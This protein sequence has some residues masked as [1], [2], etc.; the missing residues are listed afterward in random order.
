[1]YSEGVVVGVSFASLVYV[2]V[3]SVEGVD[4]DDSGK[5]IGCSVGFV[6]YGVVP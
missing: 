3:V 4:V 1:M 2:C 5:S 6:L